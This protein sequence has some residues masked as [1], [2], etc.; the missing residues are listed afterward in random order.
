MGCRATQKGRLMKD[1]LKELRVPMVLFVM[2]F[3]FVGV[4]SLCGC[5]YDAQSEKHAEQAVRNAD[6]DLNAGHSQD[7]ID[8]IIDEAFDI[9]YP[10]PAEPEADPTISEEEL[11]AYEVELVKRGEAKRAFEEKIRL[12]VLDELS[13]EIAV[14]QAEEW[15]AYERSKK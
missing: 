9:A 2:L 7:E 14:E 12:L 15:L 3:A 10:P 13:V 1:V 4:M 5:K 11:K 6:T 8:A